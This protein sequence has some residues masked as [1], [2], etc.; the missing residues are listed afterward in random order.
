MTPNRQNRAYALL[1][2]SWLPCWVANSASS[3]SALTM[4]YAA[5]RINLSRPRI[6]IGRQDNHRTGGVARKF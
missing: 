3:S 6:K 1:A 5:H 2:Q 4:E